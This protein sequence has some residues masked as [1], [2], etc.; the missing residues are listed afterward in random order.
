MATV[1]ITRIA[2]NI[3]ALNALNSLMTVNNKLATHQTRLST[4]KRINSASD[5]PAGLTIATKMLARSEG[6]KVTLDNIG[7][8]KNMLSVAEGGLSKMTD[9]ITQMRSKAEQAASDTLGSSERATIQT[10][11]SSYAQQIQDIV[12][13]TKWNGVKLL[14]QS[15][16]SKVFQTGVDEGESTTWVL[17]EKLDPTN[18]NLSEVVSAATATF[19]DVSDSFSGGTTSSQLGNMSELSTGDYTFEVLDKATGA[20][21]GKA[22]LDTTSTLVSGVNALGTQASPTGTE[23]ASGRYNIKITNVAAADDVSYVI[24]NLDDST[25]NT[26]GSMTVSNADISAGNIV[27][28]GGTNTVGIAFTFGTD[29]AG[30]VA[31]QS[32]NFEYIHSN[33]IK[34]EL[35]DATGQAT[36][37]ARNAAGSLTGSYSYKA[38]AATFQTGRGVSITMGTFGNVSAGETERF[39]YKQANNFSVDVSTAA[40]AGTYMTTANYAL[41]KVT[42]A[43]SDLGSLMARLTFKEESVATA[44]LN[45]EAGYNRIMNANM[46]EEQM[47]A[48]KYSILQQTSI[49]ML[50]QANQAPQNLLSLFR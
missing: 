3:G 1:D 9:I 49:A 6:L 50:A 34:F 43:L 26:S 5:D 2:S 37:I 28:A 23:L 45:V 31:G 22:S 18:L 48:S 46:A 27:D 39:T 14:D 19:V 35:N 40:K 21:Q 24:T 41:D 42:S 44:Q 8:A 16:G 38:A 30:L 4:G 15:T 29:P 13:Q 32:M 36:Q 10:Q 20:L 33:E 11:L 17:P 12:D 47:N 25:W 7:D